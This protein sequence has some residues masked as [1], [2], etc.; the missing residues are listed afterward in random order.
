MQQGCDYIVVFGAAVGSDGK[1]SA[2]LRHRLD[3]AVKSAEGRSRA[4]FLVTGGLGDHPP[5]EADAMR[6]YLLERGIQDRMIMTEPKGLD[7]LSS[8]VHCIEILKQRSDVES[9]VLCSS[10]FHLP[11]CWLIF[12]VL[13][14]AAR[15][16]EIQCD[17]RILGPSRWLRASVREGPAI[18]WDVAIALGRRLLS[19]QS[20]AVL[21]SIFV[22]ISMILSSGKP[23]ISA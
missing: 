15:T 16:A 14:F 3:A 7:T 5:A 20:F 10:S 9:I 1:P 8:A 2:V 21:G 12:R 4:R 23:L 11:R 13:G 6:G 19:S 18:V 17:R 22:F